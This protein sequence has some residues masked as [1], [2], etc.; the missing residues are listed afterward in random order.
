MDI[1]LDTSRSYRSL[2]RGDGAKAAD[3]AEGRLAIVEPGSPNGGARAVGG[4]DGNV[5]LP[6]L[7][8]VM[9]WVIAVSKL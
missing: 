2:P 7:R 1:G 8:S 9:S 5:P 3:V 4:S 6:S